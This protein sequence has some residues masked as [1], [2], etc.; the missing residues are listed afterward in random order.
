MIPDS[1]LVDACCFQLTDPVRKHVYKF[2]AS[3]VEVAQIWIHSLQEG[4]QAQLAKVN[5]TNLISFE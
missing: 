5:N 1:P 2:R 4:T 3:S